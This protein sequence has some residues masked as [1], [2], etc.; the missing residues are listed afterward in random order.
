[1]PSTISEMFSEI[2]LN[3]TLYTRIPGAVNFFKRTISCLLF[4]PAIKRSTLSEKNQT[5]RATISLDVSFSI[6]ISVCRKTGPCS[7]NMPPGVVRVMSFASGYYA[8]GVSRENV[9]KR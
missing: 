4:Y 1:M 9:F 8:N 7:E 2:N 6:E 3:E 5:G